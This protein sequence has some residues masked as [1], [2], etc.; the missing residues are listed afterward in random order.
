[1]KV[2]KKTLDELGYVRRG[3]SKHRPRDAAHLYDGPYPFIQTSDVKNAGLYI[4]EYTQTYSAAGLAQSKLWKA[5]T[6]CITIAANIGDTAILSFDACFPDSIVGFI[7]DSQEA[8][9]RY[10][11]YLFGT[12]MQQRFKKFTQ[13]A[14]QDNLSQQKLLS[15]K[16]PV[17]DD[18]GDQKKIADRIAIYDALI[19]VNRRRI[20]LLEESAR[21]LYR[22]WF[23]Y[24]RFPGHEKVKII[25]N[26][27]MHT[28]DG[29]EYLPITKIKIFKKRSVGVSVFVDT[30]QYYQTSEIDGTNLTGNGEEVDYENRPSRASVMPRLNAV[31]FARM[32]DTE[33]VLYFNNENSDMIE[34][35][36][37]ST[38]MAGF[39]TNEEYL[40]FLF[41]L[42]TSYE[43]VQNR[44]NYATGATQVSLS[45]SGLERIKVLFPKL[46]LTEQYSKIIN[47]LLEE[48]SNLR[49]QNQKLVQARDL[50]LPRLMSGAIEVSEFDI[51]VP[52]EAKT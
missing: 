34:K 22:E 17:A 24:F 1:M 16:L 6:L 18:V 5:G 33:K 41:G 2:V 49:K 19:N 8:D 9:A 13:G 4:T 11:K 35:I 20:Y 42:L 48:C 23:V 47:P 25:D 36:L 52:Q 21:L 38:G 15:L 28:P 31:Y 50:L 29:W 44:N 51:K 43:F 30:R 40:A 10:I 46:E 32:K 37:L 7:P 3:K 27:G 45:D 26:E 12:T 14:T 39:T